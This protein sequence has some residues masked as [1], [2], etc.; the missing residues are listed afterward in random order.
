MRNS[1][2][3]EVYWH[4]ACAECENLSRKLKT[5]QAGGNS[6]EIFVGVNQF[7]R[8]YSFFDNATIQF[9]ILFIPLL[10]LLSFS[11]LLVFLSAIKKPV[12]N[13]SEWRNDRYEC[14]PSVKKITKEL[15]Y[16]FNYYTTK[17]YNVYWF[18]KIWEMFLKKTFLIDRIS[19]VYVRM[20]DVSKFIR[21]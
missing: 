2:V 4:G 16:I 17:I 9:S 10:S 1:S 14:L 11:F 8:Y 20:A 21:P 12:L 6:Y 18:W 7:K 15:M 13:D 3:N 5:D 19:S